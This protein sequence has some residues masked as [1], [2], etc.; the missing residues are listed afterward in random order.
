MKN[1][2][3]GIATTMVGEVGALFADNIENKGS[4]NTKSHR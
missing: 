3:K 2:D 1:L 4:A